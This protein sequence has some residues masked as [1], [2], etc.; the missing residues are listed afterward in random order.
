MA[1]PYDSFDYPAYWIGRDYEHKSEIYALKSFLHRIHK[2]KTIIEVGCGFGRLYPS[3]FFRAKRVILSDPSSRLLKIARETYKKPK[4][5]KFV[6]STLN[7]LPARVVNYSADL[8]VMVRVLHHIENLDASFRAIR[9]LLAPDGYLIFE[10]AN[11]RHLKATIKNFIKGDFTFP[12]DIFTQDIRTRRQKR[13]NTIPFLNYHP[14]VVSEV[15]N[16]YGFEVIEKRSV[17]NVRSIKLK[18]IFS[19]E[20][21]F[22]VERWTQ[23]LF[24]YFDFGPSVFILARKRG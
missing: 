13:Q 8:V 7:N 18:Q 20:I 14:D 3:Y 19:T 4:N 15:L 5:L 10:F 22:A 24:S 11:K 12:L 9:K 2:I 21:L 16:K 1:S 6:Q 23:K 17:S